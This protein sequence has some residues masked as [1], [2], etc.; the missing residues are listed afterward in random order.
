MTIE[1]SLNFSV[2]AFNWLLPADHTLYKTYQRSVSHASISNVT[3]SIQQLQLCA[4]VPADVYNLVAVTPS[5]NQFSNIVH[6]T[7][8][9]N[10]KSYEDGGP[11]FQTT[12]YLRSH[13]CEVLCE[14]SK[15]TFCEG[16]E[17]SLLKNTKAAKGKEPAQP[18]GS[19]APLTLTSKERLVATVQQQREIVKELEGRISEL[20]VEIEKNSITVNESLEKDLLEIFANNGTDISPHMKVFWEQQRKLLASPKFGRR[21]HPHVIR[22]CLSLHAKSPAAYKELRDSGVL[23]LPSQ[24]TLRDYRNF[25]KPK[26]GFNSENIERLKELCSDHTGIQRYVV[27][28]LDEMKIQSK[29]VFDKRSNELI[30]FVDLGDEHVNE[31]LASGDELATHALV[32]L[33]RGVAT[34]LKY[35]LGYFLTKDVTS[36]QIMSLFWKAVCVL[37]VACNLWIC[38]AV[39][40]GASPNRRCYELHAGI[41]DNPGVPGEIVHSTVNLFCPSRKIYFFSDAPHLVKTARNCLFN[42]GSGKRTRHLWN[43]DKHLLWEHISKMYFADL[44]CGLHQLPK[45]SVDHIVLKSFS[46]MK[47]KL[48]VQVMSK[49]VSLALKRHYT[50]GEAD[51]T[52][53]LCE[54]VNNFFDCLNVRSMHEHERKRNSLLAPYRSSNDPRF[55]WLENVFLKYLA[56]WLAS[57]KVRPGLFTQEQRAQMFLS[58]QTYKGFQ[59][60]V[61]SMIEV[62]KF[63][64]AEG[65][66]CV[67]TE[68][69]CQDDLEEYFG[70]QRAQGSRSDNPTAA[71]FGYNDLRI[72]VLRDIAPAAEGNVS[73]RHSER[74]S[75]WYGVCEDPLPKRAKKKK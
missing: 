45:L 43:N 29:L 59:I 72:S 52:A 50:T 4:G 60:T 44:D 54:M 30:G 71:D 49:T 69:F 31:A 9:H 19:K 57:I 55:E 33:I 36:Y 32:F 1:T 11:S 37:E 58:P 73:G 5:S 27:L 53:K 25:F 16:A 14:C 6:H 17:K 18:V 41:S 38:A 66:Q 3:H 46:K 56:D 10:L 8:P 7:V 21:Y 74:K 15:C 68:R 34:D 42:S 13:N 70:F 12:V 62:V 35:T 22:F 24:R 61:K 40:D 65:L 75:K 23:V 67:L 63:L 51:E 48:A 64:L 47:V 39:S 28:S 20:E 26:P 2:A